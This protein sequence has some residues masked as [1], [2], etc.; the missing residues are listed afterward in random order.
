MGLLGGLVALVF[1]PVGHV[2]ASQEPVLRVLVWEGKQLRVRADSKRPLIIRGVG[3]ANKSLLALEAREHNGI[4][5]V[6]FAGSSGSWSP[7]ARF[8][9]ISIRSRDPRGIWLGKRRYRGE[10]R[11][12]LVAEGL[13]VVNYLRLENYLI[14]VVGSEMPKSWPKA[15]LQAQAVAA[16]TYALQKY[17]KPGS[18]DIKANESSQVYLGIESETRSTNEAVKKTRSLV[19]TYQGKLINAVFH[20]SSG[21][22]T[23]A[24]GDVWKKQLPYLISVPDYDQHSPVHQWD[25]RFSSKQLSKLFKEIGG[26]RSINLHRASSTGRVLE[27]KVNGPSGSLVLTGKEL[28]SRLALK[29]TLFRFKLISDDSLALRLS[30]SFFSSSVMSLEGESPSLAMRRSLGFWRDWSKGGE[31]IFDPRIPVLTKP[32]LLQ[33]LF[34]TSVAPLYSSI[35]VD[36]PPPLRSFSKANVLLIRGFGSGHG[37][38][39]SQWGAHGLA[40]KGVGFRQILTHYYK[41]VAIRSYK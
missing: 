8:S 24:S 30:D 27:V 29:S 28:R 11:V 7:I 13:Q 3:S 26:L 9:Q 14:S 2:S 22:M 38:G 6:N 20:S 37:V 33:S 19:L 25:V 18:Y 23:E 15:A 1:C 32:P 5:E 16:R 10:L 21:G 36:P 41:G 31:S 40:Q 39:M 35:A 17:G 34:G 12:S 4:F